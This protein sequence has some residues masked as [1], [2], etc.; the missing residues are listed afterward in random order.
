[1]V[2]DSPAARAGLEAGD[3]VLRVNRTQ[4]ASVDDVKTAVAKI[5]EGKAVMLLVHPADGSDRFVTLAAG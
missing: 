5:P 4:V 3:V 1:V 2:P